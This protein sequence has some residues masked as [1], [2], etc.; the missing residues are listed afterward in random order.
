TP[1]AQ[2]VNAGNN[3]TLA[4]NSG[5]TRSGFTFSGWS[6]NQD[7]SGNNYNAGVSFT[8]TA[9]I[10]LYARWVTAVTASYTVTYNINFGTGTTP[11]AQTVEAGNSVTIADGTGFA[12]SGFTFNGW[13]TD[14]NDNGTNYAAGVSFTPTANTT[15]FAR[16][17]TSATIPGERTD[18]TKVNAEELTASL[19]ECIPNQNNPMCIGKENGITNIGWI[20]PGDNATYM[21]NNIPRTGSYTMQ[22]RIATGMDQSTFTVSVNDIN[23][24]TVRVS[25]TSENGSDGWN[26]YTTVTFDNDVFLNQGTNKVVL[27]FQSAVNVDYFLFLGEKAASVTFNGG[28]KTTNKKLSNVAFKSASKGFSALL[29]NGHEFTSYSL[30]DLQGREILKGKVQYGATELYFNNIRPGVMFLKL[31]GKSGTTV[32]KAV[33]F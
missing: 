19:P 6:T 32:L 33:T 4:S 3:V 20:N 12:R 2:T 21:V 26:T 15:L 27:N 18:T 25:N 29:T 11:A 14:A 22:F 10:T 7:G 23:V 13:N 16:W 17:T 28:V 31:K 24:G 1:S 5:F 8:P 30:V 9:N